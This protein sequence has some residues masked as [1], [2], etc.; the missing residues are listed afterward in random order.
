MKF[1]ALPALCMAAL[2]LSAGQKATH[3]YS[4]KVFF[5]NHVENG[6]KYKTSGLGLQYS[7]IR[8]EGLNVRIS[9]LVNF[10]DDLFIESEQT[11][12]FSHPVTD[13]HFLLPFV[14]ART[15]NHRF[16]QME[17][18]NLYVAKSIAFCGI[19]WKMALN[20]KFTF[21]PELSLFRDLSN[22]MSMVDGSAF[23]GVSYSNPTGLKGKMG[24]QLHRDEKRFLNLEVY[25]ARTFQECYKECGAELSLNWGF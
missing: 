25:Y 15:S 22:V 23:Y 7:L 10:R 21:Q 5:R 14:S 16:K 3:T 1:L 6:Y 8:E 24:V 4:P 18:G 9:T 20:H 12:L 19:G 11:L 17:E 2:P 13:S